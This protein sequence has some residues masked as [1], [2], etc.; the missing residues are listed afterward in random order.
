MPSYDDADD[1]AAPRRAALPQAPT[2]NQQLDADDHYGP[3]ASLEAAGGGAA[4]LTETDMTTYVK[5]AVDETSLVGPTIEGFNELVQRG[6]PKIVTELFRIDISMRNE[7]QGDTPN[8]EIDHYGILVDF[9]DAHV[10]KPV[11]AEYPSGRTENYYPAQARNSGVSYSGPFRMSARVQITAHYKDGRAETRAADIAPFEVSQ[12]PIMV[13]SALCH[14]SGLTRE[15]RKQLR[16]DPKD[17]GGYFVVKGEWSVENLENICFNTGHIHRGIDKEHVRCEFISQPGGAFENSSQIIVRYLL[18]G[19]IT[20]EI[21]T[22]KFQKLQIPFYLIFRMFG[23]SN[24]M[25]ILRQVVGDLDSDSPVDRAI[26]AAVDRALHLA[27]PIFADLRDEM[28]RQVIREKLALLL[29][30]HVTNRN[31]YR[32]NEDAIRYLTNQLQG[33]MDTAFLPHIGREASYRIRKLRYLGMLLR[34]MMLVHLDVMPPADR[35]SLLVKRMHG[36]GVSIAKS[37]KAMFNLAVVSSM[38]QA[39]KSELRT[40]EFAQLTTRRIQEASRT[41]VAASSELD[42]LL[43]QSLTSGNKVIVVRR[44]A[45]LNRLASNAIERKNQLNLYSSLRRI[46]AHNASAATKGTE[47]AERIRAVHNTLLGM[48]CPYHSAD[49]GEKVGMEKQLACTAS[50]ATAGDALPLVARLAG[51]PEMLQLDGVT[52]E[53]IS[54]EGL[55]RV[56]VNGDWVGCCREPWSL[57]ARYRGMRRRGQALAPTTTVAWNLDAGRVEFWLDVGRLVRPLLIVD[58]NR[59]AYEAGRR[60]AHERARAAAGRPPPRGAYREG[61]DSEFT[62]G[63]RSYSLDCALAAVVSKPVER[64]PVSSLVEG[65]QLPD[66]ARA[67]SADTAAPVLVTDSGGRTVV[68][69][70]LHRL[71]RAAR[72]GLADLPARRIT[73]SELRACQTED[74]EQPQFVQDVRYTPAHAAAIR[75]GEL[76]LGDLLREG[77]VEYV[78]PEEMEECLLAEDVFQLHKNRNNALRKYTHCDVPQALC[79]LAA[80]VSPYAN[81]T[82]PAR[83]TYETNQGR[84]TCGWY[85]GS[86][87]FRADQLRFLQYYN[88]YPLVKTLAADLVTPSGMNTCVAYSTL[89][90]DN[91]ED[92]AA[93]KLGFIQR[94]GFAGVLFRRETVTTERGESFGTPDA[95]TTHGMRAGASYAKLVD[96]FV[97]R[98]TRVTKGDVLVGRMAK[99]GAAGSRGT[100]QG[101]GASAAAAYVDRSVVY[102]DDT[103]ATVE[104]VWET[105]GP[106]DVPTV[107]VKLRYDEM[108]NI[109]DKM[110]SRAGNKGIAAVVLC[111]SDMPYD[112]GGVA[113][114]IVIN[115]HSVP[116][117]MVIGQKLES[118]TALICA[119]RGTVVDGTAFRKVNIERLGAQLRALGLRQSGHRRMYHPYTGLPLE[120]ALFVAPT[121]QQRL[122]KFVDLNQ[123]AAPSRG[124]TDALTGQ[125]LDGKR[126]NGGLRFGEM[127]NWV[128]AAQGLT[129]LMDRK[130]RHDS[131]GRTAHYCRGCGLPADYNRA[132]GV[133]SCDECGERAD[134]AAVASTQAALVFHHELRS[135][136]ID[137]RMNFRPRTFDK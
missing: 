104:D 26:I 47:R 92:S 43:V 48:V 135:M 134:L 7:L 111:E 50:I 20:V 133:Y 84:S 99:E 39:L 121:Y 27:P 128:L 55:S 42:R 97:R 98:G 75:R 132:Q 44:R 77:V 90:G 130:L 13:G 19:Q 18:N 52:N 107:V 108:L 67:A 79:G 40:K 113:P 22:V 32:N 73:A 68:L 125:P 80:L 57:V 114:D 93:V 1:D 49:T 53:Q 56:F 4:H 72:E 115:P 78:S 12:F 9:K 61:P 86:W 15:A 38:V 51:D 123:Y 64:V 58:S 2:E 28:N 46:T 126:A 37:F 124:P 16:E 24:D 136:G 45:L 62:H 83:V 21:N 117:R 74:P 102:T 119:R 89:D 76:T 91:Q 30:R 29:E 100:R 11:K 66:A 70:G 63:G 6:I 54:R 14:T 95:T 69:D 96:G 105:Q 35:D 103:P 129:N 101:R 122:Q 106:D 23:M 112:D 36:P 110:S 82:Q 34:D 71:A 25:D 137:V 131:D 81:H 17:P 116:S 8:A 94:G 5:A 3:I 127:E 33:I 59:A 65:V 41:M 109:G 31:N 85:C 120:M 87:P 88:Q 118:Y 10:G 60:A